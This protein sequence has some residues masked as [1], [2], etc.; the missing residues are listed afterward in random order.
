[1][2]IK[3]GSNVDQVGVIDGIYMDLWRLTINN[4]PMVMIWGYKPLVTDW[5]RQFHRKP[6]EIIGNQGFDEWFLHGS[7]NKYVNVISRVS[8]QKQHDDA[9][10]SQH[11][12]QI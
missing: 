1:M 7:S 11:L 3:C 9:A 8:L 10:D 12:R 5:G 4:G 2:W 6:W